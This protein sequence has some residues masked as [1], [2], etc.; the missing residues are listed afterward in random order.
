MKSLKVTKDW[1]ALFRSETIELITTIDNKELFTKAINGQIAGN[2][3]NYSVVFKIINAFITSFCF[4]GIRGIRMIWSEKLERD[5]LQ[6]YN[7]GN[8]FQTWKNNIVRGN[9]ELE[10]S[11][12]NDYEDPINIYYNYLVDAEGEI[13]SLFQYGQTDVAA[14]YLWYDKNKDITYYSITIELRKALFLN[15]INYKEHLPVYCM[16]YNC[17]LLAEAEGLFI[18]IIN[19]V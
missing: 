14:M 8:S 4:L 5:N 1:F 16:E 2:H 7:Y 3:L 13:F 10:N 19:A 18:D 15:N 9:Y 17:K 12:G 11:F 6:F